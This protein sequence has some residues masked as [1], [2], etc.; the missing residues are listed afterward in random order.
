MASKPVA[1]TMTS[2]WM[3]LPLASM[4]P[5]GVTRSMGSERMSSSVTLGRLYI[6]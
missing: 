5:S 1:K 4:M 2:A 6:S 3:S